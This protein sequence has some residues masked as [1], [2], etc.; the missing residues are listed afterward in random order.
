MSFAT[1]LWFLETG[2][3]TELKAVYILAMLAGQDFLRIISFNLLIVLQEHLTKLCFY[4]DS[5][6][7]NIV[8]SCDANCL[9]ELSPYLLY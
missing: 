7:S 8:S 2:C 3:L 9:S 6:N 5:R 4:T 1:L